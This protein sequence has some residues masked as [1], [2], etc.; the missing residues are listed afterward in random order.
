[1]RS[2]TPPK[3]TP[4]QTQPQ[5]LSGVAAATPPATAAVVLVAVLVAVVVVVVV[6]VAVVAAAL[7]VVAI[8]T[9]C[10]LLFLTAFPLLLKKIHVLKKT[11]EKKIFHSSP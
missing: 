2:R 6:V 11:L 10:R 4:R 9:L 3:L 1:L 5:D 8:V 7:A